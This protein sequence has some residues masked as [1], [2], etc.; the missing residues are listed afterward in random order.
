MRV[1]DVHAREIA[2]TPQRV[3]ALLD[4]LGDEDSRLWPSERWPTTRFALEGPLAVGV[5]GRQGPIRQVVDAYEPG[6][7]LV[8]RFAPGL[9]LVGTHRLEVEALGADRSL[10]THTLEGR[11]EPKLLPVFPVLIRQHAALV[12]DLLDRAELLATGRVKR[13]SRWPAVVRIANA[14]EFT[15]ARRRGTLPAASPHAH[16][17]VAPRAARAFIGGVATPAGLAAIAAL[18]AAWALGWRWPGGDDRELA[19]R[20]IGAGAELPPAW[21]TAVVASALAGAAAVVRAAARS[22]ES[23]AARRLATAVAGIL[24]LRGTVSI[25]ID[26]AR[27]LTE[28]YERLD[29]TIYSPLC[30]ALGAGAAVA[31]RPAGPRDAQP[32][33]AIAF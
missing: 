14:I 13:P 30:L 23:P 25:P 4:S 22:P 21:A 12:E 31:A 26:L 15:V 5:R 2:S 20:M 27:G 29:I 32:G 16:D 8:L 18:H 6:R 19:E 17:A 9:G 11:V 7:R 3:G 28:T 33:G 24:L 1:H 10:L